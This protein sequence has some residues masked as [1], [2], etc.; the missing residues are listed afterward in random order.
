MFLRLV[1]KKSDAKWTRCKMSHVKEG[2]CLIVVAGDVQL[3]HHLVHHHQAQ[4]GGQIAKRG[5]GYVSTQDIGIVSRHFKNSC[6]RFSYCYE[7]QKKIQTHMCFDIP[8]YILVT[9]QSFETLPPS[10]DQAGHSQNKLMS[11]S[12]ESSVGWHMLFQNEK[13]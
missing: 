9:S 3:L 6:I 11:Q 12:L 13:S 10:L 5:R 2:V 8:M 4:Q 1:Q 7:S